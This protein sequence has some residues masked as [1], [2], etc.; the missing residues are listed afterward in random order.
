MLLFQH[1]RKAILPVRERGG[2]LSVRVRLCLLGLERLQQAH[3][4]GE[5]QTGSW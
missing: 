4:D 2:Q 3:D 5:W 1:E